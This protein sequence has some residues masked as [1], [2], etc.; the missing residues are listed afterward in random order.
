VPRIVFGI[1]NPGPEYAGT[2]HNLGFLVVEELARRAGARFRKARG[3]DADAAEAR[4]AGGDAILVR[5]RTYVNLC[6]PAL[7][8]V[9][10]A[11]GA[12]L[13]DLLVVVDD[14]HLPFGRLRLRSGGSDGGHN[15]LASIEGC[16]GTPEFAR[17]RVGIGDPG[18]VR[19]ERYVLERFPPEEARQLP[20][21]V[22]RAA[23]AVEAWARLGIGRAMS[24]V[25]AEPPAG[26][27]PSAGPG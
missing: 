12:G 25:N 24:L 26:L 7:R 11:S 27:D 22:G 16:L 9:A 6:G 8:S 15:G 14:F 19:R 17:L 1:G 4:L 13:P 5:P 20:G 10:E 23:D 21:A 3:A 18:R 2:R